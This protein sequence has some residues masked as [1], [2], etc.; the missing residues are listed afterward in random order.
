[1]AEKN[2]LFVYHHLMDGLG[3]L[4]VRRRLKNL[5]YDITSINFN[6]TPSYL[7]QQP[8]IN[9]AIV[10]TASEIREEIIKTQ[11]TIRGIQ[12]YNPS[13]PIGAIVAG[14]IE[15][16]EYQHYRKVLENNIP[17]FLST[18]DEQLVSSIDAFLK[19]DN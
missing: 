2:I 8:Q 13:L 17:I 19:K 16:N 11:E 14:P 9:G 6:E 12:E 1:M 7:A 18:R 15:G 4:R 10:W 5:G 3:S